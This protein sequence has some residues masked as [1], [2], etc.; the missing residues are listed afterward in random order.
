MKTKTKLWAGTIGGLLL[1]LLLL[2]GVKAGQIGAMIAVGK[3]FAPPPEAVTSATVQAGEW[4]PTRPA[5][6]T[7]VAVRAVTLGAELP[8]L[9]REVGFESGHTIR[10]GALLVRLDTSTEE[11]QLQ[12]AEAEAALARLALQRAESLRQA[13]VSSQADLDG[14][15]ARAQQAA[16]AVAGLQATIAKKIIRAPFDGRIAIRQVELGQVVSPGTPIASLQSIDPIHVEFWLPQQALADLKE[17]QEVQVRTDTF[18]GQTWPGKVTTINPEVDVA[19]RNVR[20][21]ATLANPDGR[22]RPGMFANVE[23][24]SAEKR[25]VLTI[26]ATAVMFAPYGDSVYVLGPPKPVEQAKGEAAPT[27]PTATPALVAQQR[28]VRLGERRGDLVAVLSGLSAGEAVVGSGAFKLRNGVAV[29]V[30]ND[31]APDARLAPQP[32]NP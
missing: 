28:F 31:L 23:V 17:G 2:G 1:L 21:R 9:V 5:I 14:A 27:A 4:Q 18:K 19:T 30:K 7:L 3:S 26:P 15:R 16:A 20:V 6:G 29:V 10:R 24:V 32:A 11:A 12:A 22:L 25:P 8:G 13:E